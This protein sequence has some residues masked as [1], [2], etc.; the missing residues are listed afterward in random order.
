[1]NFLFKKCADENYLIER[2]D[3]YYEI[4]SEKS[5]LEINFDLEPRNKYSIVFHGKSDHRTGLIVN[6]AEIDINKETRTELRTYSNT[7]IALKSISNGEKHI[8][9]IYRF[10]IINANNKYVIAKGSG[11]L[12]DIMNVLVRAKYYADKTNRTLLVDWR[13]TLYDNNRLGNSEFNKKYIN[14]NP[15]FKMF[16]NDY[17]D[18]LDVDLTEKTF[19]PTIWTTGNLHMSEMLLINSYLPTDCK[20]QVNDKIYNGEQIKDFGE[21]VVVFNGPNI[22]SLPK[23]IEKKYYRELVFNEKVIKESN[24]FALHNFLSK[25]AI[26]I[27]YRHGNGEFKKP[28]IYD[29]Y[30]TEIDKIITEDHIIFLCTDSAEV[31]RVF[32]AKYDKVIW[33]KD[34]VVSN[35]SGPLHKNKHIHDKL[36]NGLNALTDMYI[37]SKCNYIIHN[38]S[39]FNWYSIYNCDHQNII[40]V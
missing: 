39:S 33:Y 8:F 30:F 31:Q 23:P 29:K 18:V 14:N 20:K 17:T 1:M 38:Y 13:N 11:G 25:T 21:D 2:F 16:G 7:K 22:N 6:G 15:F 24:H 9:V 34:I 36:L 28:T 4:T 12:G 37:L 3:N 35:N 32:R 5:V 26:G 27:H 19:Y 10:S 40:S